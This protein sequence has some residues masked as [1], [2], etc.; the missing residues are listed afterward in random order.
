MCIRDSIE[1]SGFGIHQKTQ[2]RY[3]DRGRGIILRAI[4]LSISIWAGKGVFSLTDIPALTFISE[5]VGDIVDDTDGKT[6][7]QTGKDTHLLSLSS[8]FNVVDDD[9]TLMRF[10]VLRWY[11]MWTMCTV[12]VNQLSYNLCHVIHLIQDLT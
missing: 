12:V 6:M 2:F 5:Y 3:H 11:F 7:L 1:T 10:G 9:D 8:K 4:M